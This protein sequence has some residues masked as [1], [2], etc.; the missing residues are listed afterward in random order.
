MVYLNH[1]FPS[2][3]CFS[4]DYVTNPPTPDIG[5][6]FL[7]SWS[8]LFKTHSKGYRLLLSLQPQEVEAKSLSLKGSYT[9]D[10]GPR[11]P[12]GGS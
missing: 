6:P 12:R 7:N 9:S 10:P 11:G 3:K 5:T 2:G 4:Q 8:G 1:I